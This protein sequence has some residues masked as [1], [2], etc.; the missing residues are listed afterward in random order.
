MHMMPSKDM[1]RVP[2]SKFNRARRAY[3]K[4]NVMVMVTR[5]GEDCSVFMGGPAAFKYFGQ[6]TDYVNAGYYKSREEASK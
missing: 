2:K 3:Q 4:K 1:Q 6:F 5:C